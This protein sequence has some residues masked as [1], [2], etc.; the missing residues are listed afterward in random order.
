MK[1]RKKSARGFAVDPKMNDAKISNTGLSGGAAS[2]QIIIIIKFS[3]R[4]SKLLVY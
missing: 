3:T 2:G 4:N 1:E